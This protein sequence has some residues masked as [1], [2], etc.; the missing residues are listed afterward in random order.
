[1]STIPPVTVPSPCKFMLPSRDAVPRFPVGDV[2]K[3]AYWPLS[4]AFDAIPEINVL[5]L[6]LLPLSVTE[7]ATIVSAVPVA[8]EAGAV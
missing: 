7:V 1:M 6:A 4:V 5:A 8:A 2:K 3:K